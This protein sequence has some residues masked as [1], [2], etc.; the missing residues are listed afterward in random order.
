[1]SQ[2]NW[3]YR[4]FPSGAKFGATGYQPIALAICSAFREAISTTTFNAPALNRS[5]RSQGRESSS[6]PELQ[7]SQYDSTP[8]TPETPRK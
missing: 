3:R 1:M 2:L 7:N 8:E 5:V 6:F 4:R